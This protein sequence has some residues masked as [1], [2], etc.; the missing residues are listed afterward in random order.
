MGGTKSNQGTI[1]NQVNGKYMNKS[2]QFSDELVC[3]QASGPV[4]GIPQEGNPRTRELLFVY[5]AAGGF[6]S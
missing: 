5:P 3:V 1:L 4:L 6:L 2:H